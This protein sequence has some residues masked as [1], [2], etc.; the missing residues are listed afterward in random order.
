[1]VTFW[2]A[3]C[4]GSDIWSKCASKWGSD[5]ASQGQLSC[6]SFCIPFL[7]PCIAC[8][9]VE[10]TTPPSRRSCLLLWACSPLPPSFICPLYPHWGIMPWDCVKFRL[11]C[12]W[13]VNFPWK[14][15]NIFSLS[16]WSL[17]FF[18][19]RLRFFCFFSL[20]MLWLSIY[21]VA[22]LWMS[23]VWSHNPQKSSSPL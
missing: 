10:F 13:V 21:G 5:G 1:M 15:K 16:K 22:E 3:H 9:L 6:H 8:L 17:F 7:V 14:H 18:S 4:R 2:V 23:A 12:W 20:L 19:I 11:F